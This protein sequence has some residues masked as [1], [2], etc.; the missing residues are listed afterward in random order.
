MDTNAGR[1]LFLDRFDHSQAFLG[2]SLGCYDQHF[3]QFTAGNREYRIDSLLQRV[4][5][6]KHRQNKSNAQRFVHSV[7]NYRLLISQVYTT[8]LCYQVRRATDSK[9]KA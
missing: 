3:M 7:R 2:G 5:F 8:A 9:I 6:V 4:S 1:V